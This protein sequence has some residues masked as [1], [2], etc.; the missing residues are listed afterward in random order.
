[1]HQRTGMNAASPAI[2]PRSLDPNK[3]PLNRG[4]F[5]PTS[6]PGR[7]SYPP[8][9]QLFSSPDFPLLGSLITGQPHPVGA[10]Q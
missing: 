9:A 6:L 10:S 8:E 7:I 4:D 5:V 3:K 2:T 1:M